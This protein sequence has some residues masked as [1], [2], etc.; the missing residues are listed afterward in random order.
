M[1]FLAYHPCSILLDLS[2]FPHCKSQPLV[3]IKVQALSFLGEAP[4]PNMT[5]TFP[6]RE[7]LD[8][9]SGSQ[10]IPLFGLNPIRDLGA[11]PLH[12]LSKPHCSLVTSM[13]QWDLETGA[14]GWVFFATTKL[15]SCLSFIFTARVLH[16]GWR[17]LFRF[18]KSRKKWFQLQLKCRWLSFLLRKISTMFHESRGICTLLP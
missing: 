9:L 2:S 10:V 5:Q 7:S 6:E 4:I 13:S 17:L 1:W 14:G 8:P 15:V 18:Q 16:V 11:H 12:S 3:A